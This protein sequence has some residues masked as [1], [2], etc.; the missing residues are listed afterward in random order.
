MCL[1]GG[2]W[3]ASLSRGDG[4]VLSRGEDEGVLSGGVRELIRVSEGTYQG[5]I[6]LE[7]IRGDE[8]G[9]SGENEGNLSGW[10]NVAN[11]LVKRK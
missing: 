4:G 11:L 9:L 10:V 6:G 3:R 7:L 8:G 5:G 2:D 1:P